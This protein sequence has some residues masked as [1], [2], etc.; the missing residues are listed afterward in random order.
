MMRSLVIFCAILFGTHAIADVKVI[1]PS[2]GLPGDIILLRATTEGEGAKYAWTVLPPMTASGRPTSMRIAD[3]QIIVAS[4]PGQYSVICAAWD[5]SA[6]EQV[7][8]VVT[9]E[10][11][12]PVPP[13]PGP[14]PIPP[15]PVN[16]RPGGFAGDVYDEAIKAADPANAAKLAGNYRSVASQIAA[17]AAK[18]PAEAGAALAA[19]NGALTYD[20]TPWRPFAQWLGGQ[21]NERA[22]TIEGTETAFVAIAD[23]LESAGAK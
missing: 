10:G 7:L 9:I 23:G 21:L 8:W 2:G 14:S 17:G 4:I 6:L 13:G 19:L 3:D 20:R 5:G 22:K 1:G 11:V 16:P 15:D 12:A 18:T